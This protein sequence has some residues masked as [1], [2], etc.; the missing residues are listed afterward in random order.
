MKKRIIALIIAAVTAFSLLGGCS[1]GRGTLTF[2]NAFHGGGDTGSRDAD[3]GV[4]YRETLVYNVFASENEYQYKKDSSLTDDVIKYDING[5]YTVVLSVLSDLDDS[6]KAKFSTDIQKPEGSA[7]Y[8]LKSELKLTAKYSGKTEFTHEDVITSETYF[9][10]FT[11]SYMPLYSRTDSE[12]AI[13]SAGNGNSALLVVKSFSEVIYRNSS[14]TVKTGAVQYSANGEVKDITAEDTKSTDHNYSAKTV[15]DNAQLF[16][17][18]RN[19]KVDVDGTYTLPTVSSAY[20][21]PTDLA[22]K[23]M[24]EFDDD[25]TFDYNGT[26]YSGKVKVKELAYYVNSQNNTGARQFVYIQKTAVKNGDVTVAENHALPVKMVFP[27]IAY[28]SFSRLGSLVYK[29]SS[30]TVA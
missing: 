27:M 13:V 15:I 17:A 29:L 5:T 25:A 21:D 9:F 19:V 22:V 8:S 4:G 26:P 14:Y 30:V 6:T 2:N 24:Q 12:Y 7:V 20:G 28:G 3:P 23:N 1:S 16:F 11:E 18:L 10:P